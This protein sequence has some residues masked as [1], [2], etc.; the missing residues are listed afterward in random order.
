MRNLLLAITLVIAGAGWTQPKPTTTF[1]PAGKWT[2]ASQDE[3]GS[4]ASGTMTITGKPGAY[5][6][7]ITTG[8]NQEL[9]ITDVFTA[10][11]GMVILASLPDGA[12]AVVKVTTKPDGKLEA[13]WAAVRNV[14]P[15]TVERAK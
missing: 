14:I 2:Y 5:G 4:Q 3:Q 15:A 10:A 1:D 6:G 11:N 13:G 12:T 8:Q 7:T 9:P